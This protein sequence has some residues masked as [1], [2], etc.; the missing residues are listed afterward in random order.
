MQAVSDGRA[1]MLEAH[2]TPALSGP[3]VVGNLSPPRNCLHKIRAGACIE[4]VPG[5]L[6][7]P[8]A[9]PRTGQFPESGCILS[10]E[11]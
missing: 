11:R 4:V 8:V 3:T 5:R 6:R 1:S 2:L 9:P 7:L 10:R